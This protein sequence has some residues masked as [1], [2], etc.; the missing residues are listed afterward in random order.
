[1]LVC[2]TQRTYSSWGEFEID[3]AKTR[4]HND[5]VRTTFSVIYGQWHN[6]TTWGSP[7]Y[8]VWWQFGYKV[9][10]LVPEGLNGFAYNPEYLELFCYLDD[11]KQPL[12][13]SIIVWQTKQVKDLQEQINNR[14]GE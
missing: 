11:K 7:N 13:K 10:R 6:D 5:S 8:K 12:K 3:T 14:P 9:L 2:D 1:M 4:K